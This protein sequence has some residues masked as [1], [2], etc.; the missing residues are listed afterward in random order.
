MMSPSK[1][2]R[3][4][5]KRITVTRENNSLE[6]GSRRSFI[7]QYS[8]KYNVLGTLVHRHR[9]ERLVLEEDHF[10]ASV[11]VKTIAN[12]ARNF[13]VVHFPETETT[14]CVHSRNTSI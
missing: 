10:K 3:E 2:H 4:K 11:A 7:A 8:L 5:R 1:S 9:R 6:R 12:A 13:T 14:T